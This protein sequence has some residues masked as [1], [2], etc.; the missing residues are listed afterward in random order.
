M[1][2]LEI[3]NFCGYDL[4]KAHEMAKQYGSKDFSTSL[5]EL[6]CRKPKQAERVI[7]DG[8]DE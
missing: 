3:M 8:D 5:D 4:D 7:D 2:F 1:D 6:E